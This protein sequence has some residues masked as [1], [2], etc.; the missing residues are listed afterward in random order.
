MGN[1]LNRINGTETNTY[2]ANVAKTLIGIN[3]LRH[4]CMGRICRTWLASGDTIGAQ[5]ACAG[6]NIKFGKSGAAGR[7]LPPCRA[8]AVE[9]GNLARAADFFLGHAVSFFDLE[10]G[11]VGAADFRS[12]E[13]GA[14]KI[15]SAEIGT[16]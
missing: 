6:A 7:L 3:I 11:Q 12:P 2:P 5:R 9:D 4:Q 16:G 8:S 15:G 14:F 1:H 13:I 10:L